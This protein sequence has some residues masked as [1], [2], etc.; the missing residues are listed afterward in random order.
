MKNKQ[1]SNNQ[2]SQ[3]LNIADVNGCRLSCDCNVCKGV[4]MIKPGWFKPGEVE[5][6]SDFLG[7][8]MQELFDEYLAVDWYQNK[9][10]E[11]FVLS[12]ATSNCQTGEMFPFN[13]KGRCVFFDNGKCKIHSFAPYE[14]REYYHDQT[15]LECINRHKEVAKMWVDKKEYLGNLLGFEPHATE[16][17]SFLEMFGM[18]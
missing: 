10:D 4:C 15:H 14:C 7:I 12:P 13:P 8:T 1:N 11:I 2:H 18:F 17:D 6:V 3:Q 5:K 9:G 16:P